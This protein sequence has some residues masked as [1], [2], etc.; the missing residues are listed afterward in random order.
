MSSVTWMCKRKGISLGKR[1][2]EEIGG[3]LA[4]VTKKIDLEKAPRSFLRR[5][6]EWVAMASTSQFHWI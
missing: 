6:Q 4:N 1:G 5:T 3:G 2:V